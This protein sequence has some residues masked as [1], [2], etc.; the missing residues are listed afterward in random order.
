MELK[1]RGDEQAN[2]EWAKALEEA[3]V[4]VVYGLVGLKT[5]A[6]LML[7]VRQEGARRQTLC[8]HWNRQLQRSDGRHVRGLRAVYSRS[9][10]D[11]RHRRALQLP[12]R[13]Q[14]PEQL[15]KLL[16]AP[17]TLRSGMVKLIQHEALKPEGRI[18]IKVNNLV[19]P[20]VIDALYRASQ[21]GVRDRPHRARN[22]LSQAGRCRDCQTGFR[23]RSLVGHYLE[24]SR[25]FCF[26]SEPGRHVLIGSS[27]LMPRNLDRRVE[28][29]VPVADPDLRRE[30]EQFLEL[31]L[32]DD[33]LAWE[34]AG[35]GTWSKAGAAWWS[36][37]P[38]GYAA[39]VAGNRRTR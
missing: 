7:V 13:L 11:S 21:A 14:P 29:V 19:D 37:H 38:G 34:L 1:A 5:H 24:H 18:V 23:V 20:E 33:T 2:I 30:I 3:G 35:D 8:A 26:G 10:C 31:E 4:H 39:R 6:K 9:G 27:D 22:L 28:A 32:T 36:E 12:H 25:I 15:P 17:T 16:V